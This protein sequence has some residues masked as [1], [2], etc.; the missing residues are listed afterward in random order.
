MNI[1]AWFAK[2]TRAVIALV[3]VV[4][5][6]A[7]FGKSIPIWSGCTAALD[8]CADIVAIGVFQGMIVALVALGYTLVYGILQLI[9]FANGSVFMLGSVGA[10]FGVEIFGLTKDTPATT[11]ILAFAVILPV[12]MLLTAGL[13][14]GIERVAYRPLR[15]APTL[16]TLISAIGMDF[17]LQNVGQ[18]LIGPSPVSLPSLLPTT[19]I[20]TEPFVIKV[21]HVFVTAITVPLLIGLMW[22][23]QAT[24]QGKAMRATAQDREAA[25]LMGIDVNRT[26]SLTFLLAGALAGGAG[27]IVALYNGSAWWQYG[28][29]YGLLAFTAAVFG[30]I[31]NLLGA[32]VGGIFL[33]VLISLNAFY[34]DPRWQDV[35]V[36]GILVVV[37]VFRPTGLFAAKQSERA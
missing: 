10:L 36:F 16:A 28:F 37:L 24:R 33:G 35:V 22:F 27:V 1:A 7:V 17:I 3:V 19:N 31:G 8:R 11:V 34:V 12:T 29:S 2:N 32:A 4:A 15:R 30:G 9:N 14:A 18:V 20:I 25:G 26:I 21:S 6:L 13:N 23:V 5:V